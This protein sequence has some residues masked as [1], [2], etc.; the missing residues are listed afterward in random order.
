[1]NTAA[2]PR[3]KPGAAQALIDNLTGQSRTLLTPA[4]LSG[5]LQVPTKTLAMW[6]ATNRVRLPFIK[7]GN[8]VR[9]RLAD[10]EQFLT[11]NTHASA[12]S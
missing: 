9:Y 6:R 1:M 11:D 10:V 7:V 3:D 8:A 5:R 2:T 12:Q 4:E